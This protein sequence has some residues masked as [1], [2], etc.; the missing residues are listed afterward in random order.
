L[1]KR[2]MSVGGT[3]LA[4]TALLAIGATSPAQA[5]AV[6]KCKSSVKTFDIPK[7][8]DTKVTI[9]LCV[10]GSGNSRTAEAKVSWTSGINGSHD[11]F[12]DFGVWLRLERKDKQNAVAYGQ[13]SGPI[14]KFP[15]SYTLR[16][17]LKTNSTKGGWT[18][19]GVVSVDI[20]N[21]GKGPRANWNLAGTPSIN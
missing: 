13:L 3:V 15:G 4:T 19:D 7:Q 18:A 2:I 14:G 16:T 8:T 5:A 6:T 12:D 1:R 10:S 21:D 9:K 20:N 17:P 11:P